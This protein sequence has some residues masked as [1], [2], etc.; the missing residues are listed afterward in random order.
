[1][2]TDSPEHHAK[3]LLRYLPIPLMHLTLTPLQIRKWEA[4]GLPFN[5]DNEL[6]GGYL[7]L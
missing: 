4:I 5:A 1:M 6:S 7:A 2:R 3:L